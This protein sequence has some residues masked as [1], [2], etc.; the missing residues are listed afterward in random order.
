MNTAVQIG[1][2][3]ADLTTLA[4]I[5]GINRDFIASYEAAKRQEA[6]HLSAVTPI[7]EMGA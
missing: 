3:F 5:G 7:N 1:N 4:I 2:T 6:A